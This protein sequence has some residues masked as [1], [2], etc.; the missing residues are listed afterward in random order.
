VSAALAPAY[1]VF[2]SGADASVHNE[3][4]FRHFLAIERR[5]AEHAGRSV[6]LVLV[7]LCDTPGRSQRLTPRA[8]TAIFSALGSS[9][10][11]VDFVGW[12]RDGHV[13]AAAVIQRGRPQPD[14]IAARIGA[15][16]RRDLRETGAKLR[17][18]AVALGTHTESR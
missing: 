18:R 3:A 17:L 14:A 4:A 2:R 9:V 8:A 16:L 7:S 15:T 10:R 11:D 6:L 12:F 1:A 5:R 13:A